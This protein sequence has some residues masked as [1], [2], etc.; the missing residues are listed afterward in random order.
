MLRCEQRL[1]RCRG[2]AVAC[3]LRS[4]WLKSNKITEIAIGA[5][6][7]ATQLVD[8]GLGGNRIVSVAEEAFHDLTAFRVRPGEFKPINADGTPFLNGF[9]SGRCTCVR[10]PAACAQPN[11]VPC[12]VAGSPCNPMPGLT[13]K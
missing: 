3:L 13:R 8:L 7:G 11:V 6:F 1:R 4:L 5:F 10:S 9:G 2:Q 12:P